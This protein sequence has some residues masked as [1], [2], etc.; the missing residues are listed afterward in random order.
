[1]PLSLDTLTDVLSQT[2]HY[3]REIN[4][5]AQVAGIYSQGLF[6]EVIKWVVAIN[7]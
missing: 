1:M 2:R 4:I 3:N 5:I 7:N 6:C